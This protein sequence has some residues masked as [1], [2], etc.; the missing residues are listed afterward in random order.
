MWYNKIFYINC[1][2]QDHEDLQLGS[3]SH[4]IKQRATGYE[5]LPLFPE[6]P[7]PG[8]LR[9]VEPIITPEEAKSYKKT[10][11]IKHINLEK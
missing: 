8:D 10:V 6:Q 7:P 1:F 11:I 3:L 5:S 4:Y 9:N 2:I